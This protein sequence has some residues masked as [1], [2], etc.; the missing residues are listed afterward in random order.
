ML[1][2]EASRLVGSELDEAGVEVL[3]GV[4]VSDALEDE[5]RVPE[6]P[7]LLVGRHVREFDHLISLPQIVG[8]FLAGTPTDA[9][10]FIEVD[11]HLKVCGT[12]RVWAAGRCIAAALEHDGLGACQA[13]AAV[14]AIAGE[15]DVTPPHLAGILLSGQREAWL[16]E[17]PLGAAEP[18]TR[19][20]WWPS[21]RAVGHML[22]RRIAA[23]DP[24][25]EPRAPDRPAGLP[26][27]APVALG[28]NRTL[29]ASG[30]RPDAETRQA[31]LRDIEN[32]QLM[33]VRRQERV[34]EEEL[35]ALR[36]RL[37]EFSEREQDVVR[38]LQHHGYLQRSRSA[39]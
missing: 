20:L 31:R 32:R 17:N 12:A 8:P 18:S 10:G 36:S 38:D 11:E 22:A 21:G 25:V 9:A 27:N 6:R 2:S 33:A 30:A 4:E 14:A 15:R 29:R 1:G 16:A 3:A 23:W 35:G 34:A 5:A 37:A 24:D 26:I 19:C 39:S 7:R 13:D 28:C